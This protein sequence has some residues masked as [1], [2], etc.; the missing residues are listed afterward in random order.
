M[1][2]RYQEVR[3]DRIISLDLVVWL[4]ENYKAEPGA[5]I[6]VAQPGA[7][8]KLDCSFPWYL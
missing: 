5:V 3:E 1:Y 4:Y 8:K 7:R 6:D 2:I